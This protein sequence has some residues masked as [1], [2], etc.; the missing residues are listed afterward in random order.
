[1]DTV[2]SKVS[3]TILQ[4]QEE[5]VVGGETY[6]VSPPSAA[7]LILA[8]EAISKLPTVEL[9]PD[10]IAIESLY[11]A[12]DCRVLG[13]IIAIL[14]LGAKNIT[15]TKKVVTKRLFGLVSDENEVTI[16]NKAILAK[17][18]LENVE[19]R[20]LH[21]I[22]ARLLKTM[23]LSDFFGLTVSLIEINLLQK[24]RETVMTASGQ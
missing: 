8:S 4:Q 21:E 2:E 1:M 6:K 12:K 14:I 3:K 7:T 15:E 17:K 24:T 11:I 10:D 9:N 13:D 20:D 16:D 18:L 22:M 23:Q 5:V 19:P